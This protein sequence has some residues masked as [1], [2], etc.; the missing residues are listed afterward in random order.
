VRV[1]RTLREKRLM[2]AESLG[3]FVNGVCN[4]VLSEGFRDLKRHQPP[5]D[6]PVP[7]PDTTTP[8]P[9][10]QLI[11][12]ERQ[13]AVR[14]VIEAMTPANRRLL[15]EVVLEE[16][17]RSEV[18]REFHVTPDYLRVL[19]HRAKKEFRALYVEQEEASPRGDGRTARVVEG[20]RPAVR[21]AGGERR[22]TGAL[23]L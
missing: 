2:S 20:D 4:R 1:F 13:E 9:E 7:Q 18:C 19:L 8:S 5:A 6:D 12:G 22:S 11:T 3:A 10:M 21:R 23:G 15:R 16:R 14:R 17:D